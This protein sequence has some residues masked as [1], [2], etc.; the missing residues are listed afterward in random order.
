MVLDETSAPTFLFMSIPGP[1][2]LPSSMRVSEAETDEG[3]M[4]LDGMGLPPTY[5]P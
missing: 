2:L 4:K 5:L 3:A 1:E